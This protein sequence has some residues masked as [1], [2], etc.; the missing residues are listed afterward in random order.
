[1]RGSPHRARALCVGVAL[2]VLGA[3][4]L[5]T[6]PMGAAQR[7]TGALQG[8][9]DLQGRSDESGAQVRIFGPGGYSASTT[10]DASGAWRFEGLPTGEY[11]V[12]IEM[13]RYLDALK[14]GVWV[15]SGGVTTLSRVKLLGGD[16]AGAADDDRVDILD[17]VVIAGVFGST[18]GPTTR[19]DINGDLAINV[20]DVVMTAGNYGLV[21]PVP[22]PPSGS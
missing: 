4:A 14:V 8:A 16:C 6:R 5:A 10:T 22:W 12:E 20:L 19:A 17:M 21:S 1:M 7:L 13:E 18:V 2:F 9:V 11:R 3:L 15:E